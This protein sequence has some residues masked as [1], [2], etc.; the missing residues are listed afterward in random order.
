MQQDI[1]HMLQREEVCK[2]AS[3]QNTEL[4]TLVNDREGV[5]ED[6]FSTE[7]VAISLVRTLLLAMA[8]PKLAPVLVQRLL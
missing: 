3:S 1:R 4:H 2:T 8:A 7:E 6:R 5:Y